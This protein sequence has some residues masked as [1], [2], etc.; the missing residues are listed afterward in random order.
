MFMDI[1]G[2]QAMASCDIHFCL[3]D[4]RYQPVVASLRT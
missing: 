2:S 1:K 4:R 3:D